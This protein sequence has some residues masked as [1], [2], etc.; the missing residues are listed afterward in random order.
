MAD[1]RVS[2]KDLSLSGVKETNHEI[3]RGAYGV[4]MEYVVHGGL[5]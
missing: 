1:L 2:L 3:G 5:R 4:V